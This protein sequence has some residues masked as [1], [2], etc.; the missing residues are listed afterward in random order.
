MRFSILQALGYCVI[1]VYFL[2]CIAGFFSVFIDQTQ[3]EVVFLGEQRI[4]LES[5]VRGFMGII[6]GGL[7]ISAFLSFN[8]RFRVSMV[9]LF[10][11]IYIGALLFLN[12]SFKPMYFFGVVMTWLFFYYIPYFSRLSEY[13]PLRRKLHNVY[14]FTMV[15]LLFLAIAPIFLLAMVY[16]VY[17]DV[18]HPFGYQFYMYDGLRGFSLDRVQYSYVAGLA[19]LSFY[20]SKVKNKNV[21]LFFIIIG[22][23]MCHSRAVIVCLFVALN[24][25]FYVRA[26]YF[27]MILTLHSSL[28]LASRPE[29]L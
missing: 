28:F 26:R 17:G 24:Y 27:S 21:Y 2:W 5:A 29:A 7:A 3:R 22:L 6:L 18:Y 16:L 13:Q 14:Y 1:V 25:H 4:F 20:L 15:A 11:C 23:M 9:F 12:S 19:F 8:Q 10:L